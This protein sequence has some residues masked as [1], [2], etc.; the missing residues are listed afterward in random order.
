MTLK[1]S[2]VLSIASYHDVHL[3]HNKVPASAIIPKLMESTF[4]SGEL[5]F[6]IYAGDVFDRIL[7]LRND[8]VGEI[9][10]FGIKLLT[11]CKKHNIVLRFL[12]GTPYHDNKQSNL[13]VYLNANYNIGCDIRHVTELS[14]EHIDAL[15]INVLY[16]PDEWNTDPEV[17][18]AD[19]V[20]A[21]RNA[22]LEKVDHIV[23][24]GAFEFQLPDQVLTHDSAKWLGLCYGYIFC[25]HIHKPVLHDRIVISGSFDRLQH[26]EEEPK[27]HY[28]VQCRKSDIRNEDY[29]RSRIT[30]E[31]NKKATV[32]KTIVVNGLDEA[33]A[34]ARVIEALSSIPKKSYVRI[35]A[36]GNVDLK[37]LGNYMVT[38]YPNYHWDIIDTSKIRKVTRRATKPT[39]RTGIEINKDNIH[40]LTR[41]RLVSR[42]VPEIVID[43]CMALLRKESG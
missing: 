28:R 36:N 25:G 41:E 32:F 3:G 35:S 13:F 22:G 10:L 33:G 37:V 40:R 15:G 20:A 8:A 30:F 12:E 31:V 27:G 34:K 6:I 9:H 16:V 29:R 5:D 1:P 14:V 39:N 2:D 11:F 38:E 4:S 17:T 19:A 43:R 42:N 7:F 26:N 24:H 23:M 21:I 18:Y